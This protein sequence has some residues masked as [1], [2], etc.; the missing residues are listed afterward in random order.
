MAKFIIT[1]EDRY[2]VE[3]ESAEQALASYRIQFDDA[4]PEIF[5]G[6]V[7][8]QDEFEYLDGQAKA[9]EKTNV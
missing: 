4:D 6:K 7:I 3:A 8:D 2:E 9:E 1:V 5:S